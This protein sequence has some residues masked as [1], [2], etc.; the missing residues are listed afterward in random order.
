[1]QEVEGANIFDLVETGS[2]KR[3]RRLLEENLGSVSK[4]AIASALRHQG[5]TFE[6]LL[7]RAEMAKEQGDSSFFS[8]SGEAPRF[9][10]PTAASSGG[11]GGGGGDG[12]QSRRG[13][14]GGGSGGGSGSTD[15]WESEVTNSACEGSGRTSASASTS[16]AGG[17]HGSGSGSGGS[18][19]GTSEVESSSG[20]GGGSSG[21][22]GRGGAGTTLLVRAHR[23]P[24]PPLG[25]AAFSVRLEG[26]AATTVKT[27]AAVPGGAGVRRG[28]KPPGAPGHGG[29]GLGGV[30]ATDAKK[31]WE[32]EAA[33]S[34]DVGSEAS[35]DSGGGGGGGGGGGRGAGEGGKASMVN[36]DRDLQSKINAFTNTQK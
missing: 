11:G 35:G 26:K 25:P 28:G 3:L 12:S 22:L 18:G 29:G 19:S 27:A 14:G 9:P 32:N 1:M 4:E 30:V 5:T 2:H 13:V 36:I 24:L 10:G 33:R 6:S 20:G 16:S 23:K 8:A 34:V 7:A 31:A 17:G 15:D 21:G